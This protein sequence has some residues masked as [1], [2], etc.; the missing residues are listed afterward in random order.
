MHIH[1]RNVQAR[2]TYSVSVIAGYKPRIN[3]V[4]KRKEL[5]RLYKLACIS[6]FVL[7]QMCLYVSWR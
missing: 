4:K 5:V 1:I 3:E 7:P 2:N 6:L